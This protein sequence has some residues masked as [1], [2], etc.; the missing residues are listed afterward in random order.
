MWLLFKV[1]WKFYLL[2]FIACNDAVCYICW[3]ILIFFASE[4][5]GGAFVNVMEIG[6]RKEMNYVFTIIYA[7][8][9]KFLLVW[10]DN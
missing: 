4:W 5:N 6:E 2:A 3:Y 8:I 1:N 10:F 7:N 9:Y